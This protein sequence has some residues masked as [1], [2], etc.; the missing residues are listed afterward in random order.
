MLILDLHIHPETS[1]NL[2]NQEWP[3]VKERLRGLFFGV[4]FSL[5]GPHTLSWISFPLQKH[6]QKYLLYNNIILSTPHLDLIE[7]WVLN[8]NVHMNIVQKEDEDIIYGLFIT[9]HL[10]TIWSFQV[11]CWFAFSPQFLFHRN[12]VS[13]FA[14]VNLMKETS[15]SKFLLQKLKFL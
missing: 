15:S 3:G 14:F 2:I 4:A 8:I 13:D 1:L 10:M 9:N 11:L 12:F 6:M 7:E 5:L